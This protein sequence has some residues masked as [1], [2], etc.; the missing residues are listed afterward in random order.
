M[1]NT[2]TLY[3]CRGSVKLC[4]IDIMHVKLGVDTKA[5]KKH[6]HDKEF[7]FAHHEQSQI[8]YDFSTIKM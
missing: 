5:H 4:R 8:E 2:G 6:L 7:P 1:A 3:W